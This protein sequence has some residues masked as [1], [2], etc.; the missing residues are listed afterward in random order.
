MNKYSFKTIQIYATILVVIFIMSLLLWEKLHGGVITHHILQ[1]SDLP[2]ISNWWG[3][4]LLPFLCWVSFNKVHK[5][6]ESLQD[7]PTRISV[8]RKCILNFISA[9]VF[10]ILLSSAF[11]KGYTNFSD[12]LVDGLMLLLFLIPIY[13]SEYIFGFIL[14]MTTAIGAVLPTAFALVVALASAFI[15]LYIRPVIVRILKALTKHKA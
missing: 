3:L 10:G 2:G 9:L 7:E 13:R 6:V 5:R 15:Y 1:R 12:Y 14:G 8:I 4:P 11:S